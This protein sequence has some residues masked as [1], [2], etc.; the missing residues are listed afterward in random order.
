MTETATGDQ[1]IRS[2]PRNFIL[3]ASGL[4]AI[5]IFLFV[6]LFSQ[7][8]DEFVAKRFSVPR[9]EKAYGFK[10]GAVA[11]RPRGT[12]LEAYG[13]VETAPGGRFDAAG[14]RPGDVAE[15]SELRRAL[16]ASER[17]ETGSFQVV[18]AADWPDRSAA[19]TI[20]LPPWSSG[21]PT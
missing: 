4:A 21:K 7:S 19:R 10:A 3:V 18:A 14:V 6:V 12:P 17:G 1:Q 11:V 20:E 5:G 9:F 2:G 15:A 13:I 8:F 16:S